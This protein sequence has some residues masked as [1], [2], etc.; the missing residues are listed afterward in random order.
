MLSD[1]GEWVP[2][3]FRME[4]KTRGNLRLFTVNI[5]NEDS[6]ASCFVSD[7]NDQFI[8]L[9]CK[10][11]SGK[12]SNACLQRKGVSPFGIMTANKLVFYITIKH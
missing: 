4:E 5:T 11:L 3:K 9:F 2:V 8:W 7:I 1:F 10:S 6:H 12:A